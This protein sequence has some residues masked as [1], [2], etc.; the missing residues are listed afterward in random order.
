MKETFLLLSVISLGCFSPLKDF[1][2]IIY[3]I[4]TLSDQ[5]IIN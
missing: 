2:I 4:K 3:H 1:C 5:G